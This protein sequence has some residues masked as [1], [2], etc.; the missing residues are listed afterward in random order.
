MEHD[1][2]PNFDTLVHGGS[3]PIKQREVVV[4]CVQVEHRFSFTV[5]IVPA[6][7]LKSIRFP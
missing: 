5:E 2:L 1:Y 4:N 7:K 6:R 3:T